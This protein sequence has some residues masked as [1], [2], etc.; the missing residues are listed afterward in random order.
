MYSGVDGVVAKGVK[1]FSIIRENKF[2]SNDSVQ[3][4]SLIHDV[5]GE[6]DNAVSRLE[7]AAAGEFA[8]PEKLAALKDE[9]L[10]ANEEINKLRK[11]NK[12]V[13]ARLDN[14]IHQIRE[15]LGN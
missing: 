14:A 13:S 6:L 7:K 2:V 10:V 1:Y 4:S 11:R 3:N 9:L 12:L 15:I 5:K 8:S